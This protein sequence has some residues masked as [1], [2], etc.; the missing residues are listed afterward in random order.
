MPFNTIMQKFVLVHK[1]GTRAHFLYLGIEIS[2]NLIKY[3]QK[4]T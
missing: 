3:F 1:K 2:R 4:C